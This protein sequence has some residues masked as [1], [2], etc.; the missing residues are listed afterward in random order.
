MCSGEETQR[1]DALP[2]GLGERPR[3]RRGEGRDAKLQLIYKVR[4]DGPSIDREEHRP[5][6]AIR[7]PYLFRA[8]WLV[9]LGAD[10]QSVLAA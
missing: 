9:R 7:V 8:L 4:A 10:P 1:R 6:G 5:L 3:T 2:M